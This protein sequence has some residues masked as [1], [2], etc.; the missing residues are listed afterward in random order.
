MK[1][2][3]IRLCFEGWWEEINYNIGVKQGSLFSTTL[4]GI[5]IDMLED[6]LEEYDFVGL[7]I[8]GIVIILLLYIDD[9]V[10]MARTTYDLRKKLESSRNFL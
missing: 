5:H 4:F 1:V 6:Y 10:L 8:I 3:T 7:N 2:I 9:I